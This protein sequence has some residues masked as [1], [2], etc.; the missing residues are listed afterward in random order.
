M[1]LPI[2]M[3]SKEMNS[4]LAHAIGASRDDDALPLKLARIQGNQAVH[5]TGVC[6]GR[7]LRHLDSIQFQG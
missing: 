7:E 6:V 4:R 2:P 1:E 3:F 5:W